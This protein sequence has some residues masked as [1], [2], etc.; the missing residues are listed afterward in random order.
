[1]DKR[2]RRAPDAE[3]VLMYRLGLSRKR[4]A[5]LV[6][7]E[8]SAVGYHLVVARRRDPQLE[9]AHLAAATAGSAP[10]PAALARMEEIIMWVASEDRFPRDRSMDKSERSMARWFS[11]R[12]REVD[13]GTLHATYG[14][15]LARVPGWDRDPRAAAEEARWHKLL[16]QL[17][18]FRAEGNDWP[19]HKKCDSEREHTLGV[20]LHAQRQKRR[21]GELESVKIKLLDD[22]IPGWKTGRT[23]GR[24][25]RR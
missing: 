25:P 17:V 5:E 12:R 24:P 3:W 15:G 14:E 22:A 18:Q 20:W 8:P 4:I 9:A 19:R 6:R 7:A 16:A 13:Q 21:L 11:D 1:M 23:R 10:S 2:L